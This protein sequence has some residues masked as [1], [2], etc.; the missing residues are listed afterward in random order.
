MKY[1]DLQGIEIDAPFAD[2]FAYIEDAANLPEW[3]NAFASVNGSRA[4]MRTPQGEAEIEL[5]VISRKE[6]GTVDWKMT[7]PDG[8]VGHAYSRVVALG[9]ER[10]VYNFVLPAPPAPLE[11]LEGLLQEQSATL[12]KELHALKE[13]LEG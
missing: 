12:T 4:V 7:F 8:S 13:R 5:G 10:C 11:R 2:V 9:P 1:H 3:T 6:P